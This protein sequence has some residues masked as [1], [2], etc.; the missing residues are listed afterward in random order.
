MKHNRR[1]RAERTAAATGKSAV[2]AAA[3]RSSSHCPLARL[4]I[5]ALSV[6]NGALR[7]NKSYPN[8]S[9]ITMISG[10]SESLVE[11]PSTDSD[12]S[13]FKEDAALCVPPESHE[14]GI[15]TLLEPPP[16][17]ANESALNPANVLRYVI[18]C[19]GCI[20]SQHPS[21]DR[22]ATLKGKP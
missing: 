17:C 4:R 8:R 6:P 1:G 22:I 16:D 21:L 13:S 5:W 9:A 18:V 3:V 15:D 10:T 14:F 2:H 12:I 19:F 20:N 11:R 7:A